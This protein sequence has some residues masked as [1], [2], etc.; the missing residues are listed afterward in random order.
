MVSSFVSWAAPVVAL[1][2]M[3]EASQSFSTWNHAS[4]SETVA[5]GASPANTTPSYLVERLFGF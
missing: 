1:H 3:S 5:W 2:L 4:S